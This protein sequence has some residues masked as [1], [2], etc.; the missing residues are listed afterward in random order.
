[1]RHIAGPQP[2]ARQEQDDRAVTPPHDP[3]AITRSD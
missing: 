3:F 1:L 2:E